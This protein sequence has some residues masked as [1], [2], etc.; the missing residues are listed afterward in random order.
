MS[1]SFFLDTNILVYTFDSGSPAKQK[2]ARLLV[3]EALSSHQGTISYQV[4]QEFLNVALR[5]FEPRMSP[6]QAQAYLQRVLMPLC[7]VF[8]D[9]S[10]YSEALSICE[11]TGWSLYDCLVVSA[12][13]RSRSSLLLTED[14][15]HGR[16]IRGVKIENPFA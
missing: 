12:A 14:L 5:K 13:V 9:A 6:P 7:E 8:P 11:E 1:A 15:Q 3:E 10:L 2:K 16:I 4:V